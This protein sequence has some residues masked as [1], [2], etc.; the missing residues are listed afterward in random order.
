M[1][2]NLERKAVTDHL[3]AFW[4]TL[5]PA[6][7]SWPIAIPN[8]DFTTPTNS[9]FAVFSLVGRGSFRQAMGTTFPKRHLSTVQIDIYTPSGQGTKQS[10][11]IA[12]A[13]E[14]EYQDLVINLADGESLKF[15]TPTSRTL[16]INEQR[17]SNLEDN[18]DR[19]MVEAPFYRD[20]IVQK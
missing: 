6:N 14:L 8:Q 3:L 13:L 10:R 19:Y 2:R 17:A 7:T 9:L 16:A 18:W 11:I 5:E 1:S 4:E 20:Q 12:D 15:G